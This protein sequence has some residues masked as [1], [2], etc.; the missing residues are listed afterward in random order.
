VR[1]RDTMRE[2]DRA[3]E[4]ILFVVSYVLLVFDPQHQKLDKR[5]FARRYRER[6]RKRERE[7]E[8]EKQGVNTHNFLLFR[9]FNL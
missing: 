7:R 6:E 3:R 2:Q 1:E 4:Y 9:L 8:R 5:R